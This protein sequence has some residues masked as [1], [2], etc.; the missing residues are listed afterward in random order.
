MAE[1]QPDSAET[2]ALLER[3]AHHDAR[4]LEELLVRHR[5]GL[6]DFIDFHLDPR[7]RARRSVGYRARDADGA[8]AAN[9]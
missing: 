6:R 4:A 5:V 3:V 2:R 1:V 7:L 8:C 9:G